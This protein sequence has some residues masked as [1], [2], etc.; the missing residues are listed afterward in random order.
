MHSKLIFYTTLDAHKYNFKSHDKRVSLL[1]SLNYTSYLSKWNG[2]DPFGRENIIH[3]QSTFTVHQQVRL[4]VRYL[5]SVTV[6]VCVCVWWGG[7]G[8]AWIKFNSTHVCMTSWLQ[9]LCKYVYSGTP[10]NQP[11]LGSVKVSLLEGWPHFRGEFVLK[12][13]ALGLFEVAWIQGWPYFR[14]LD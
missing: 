3:L 5:F 2:L 4:L 9:S 10:L 11:P 14:G 8:G 7:G 13:H 6:C 12:K 1:C